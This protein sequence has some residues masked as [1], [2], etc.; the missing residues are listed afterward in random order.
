[1]RSFYLFLAIF[2]GI[3]FQQGYYYSFLIK[4]I[5]AIVCFFSFIDVRVDRRIFFNLKVFYI[6]LTIVT[7]SFSLFYLINFL[8]SD[9]ALVAF[10]LAI[11]PTA[12]AAPVI[13]SFLQGSVEYV[14]SSTLVTNCLIA[15]FLPFILPAIAKL[16][17]QISTWEI[18]A[19]NL[20]II[21]IPLIFSQLLRGFPAIRDYLIK[22]KKFSFY[23]WLLAIYLATAKANHFIIYEVSFPEHIVFYIALISFAIC[24]LNFSL[25]RLLGGK[26]LTQEASQALGQKNTMFTIWISLSFLSPI[27]ALGAMFYVVYQNLYNSYLLLNFHRNS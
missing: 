22:I 23:G 27:V 7:L 15:L 4:Y 6:F 17:V 8:N 16:H 10:M 5:V 24:V 12:L 20:K 26:K 9:M 1:M 14:I 2:L 25:G 3:V 18:L 13:T 21:I 19:S 11:A